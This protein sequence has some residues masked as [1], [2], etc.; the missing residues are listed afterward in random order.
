ME[1][2]IVITTK[3]CTL[4]L[5]SFTHSFNYYLE[6]KEVFTNFFEYF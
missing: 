2:I 3:I 4:L 1:L 5:L 6:I